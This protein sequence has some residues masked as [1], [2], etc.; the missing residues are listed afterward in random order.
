MDTIT[1]EGTV[2]W[3]NA[4]EPNKKFVKP[5]GVYDVAI[6]LQPERAE[7]LCEYLDEL[8]QK[9]L[10][11]AIKEAPENKRKQLSESLSIVPT[12]SKSRDMDGNETGETLIK[13]KLSAVV[14]K[15]DGGSFTQKPVVWDAAMGIS[16]SSDGKTPTPI[17]EPIKVTAK[18]TVKIV[19][20]PYPYVMLS[21]KTVGVSLR[22]K[23]LQILH[24]AESMD[25]SDLT[26]VEGGFVAAAVA[27]D[28]NQ[29][30][31]FED[32]TSVTPQ[33]SVNDERD[34]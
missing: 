11:Q 25:T 5:H 18:S 32:D 13:A 12:G 24:L 10:D 30:A 14:E 16:S 29:E 31:R 22:F 19:V 3:C 20:E 26:P 8:A 21:N 27:K 6:N 28:D 33:D 15:R 17:T 1:I 7:K 4:F 34:F 23:Q 9:K 2:A